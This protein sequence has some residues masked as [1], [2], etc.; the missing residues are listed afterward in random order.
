MFL[1]Q[2]GKSPAHDR[3][4]LAW[5][6]PAVAPCRAAPDAGASAGPSRSRASVLSTE[7]RRG[8]MRQNFCRIFD[9]CITY[10]LP[11]RLLMSAASSAGPPLRRD[12]QGLGARPQAGAGSLDRKGA[13]SCFAAS[14]NNELRQSHQYH[15]NSMLSLVR[16]ASFVVQKPSGGGR[17]PRRD[18]WASVN[19]QSQFRRTGRSW[20]PIVPNKPN[21]GGS[22]GGACGTNKANFRPDRKEPGAPVGSIVR[23]KAKKQ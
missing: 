5:L 1:A 11:K 10:G 8:R 23:N 7:V 16:S 9:F 13:P 18:L 15:R 20:R 6:G 2:S 12:R 17:R 22:I 3:R 21:P 4:G 14:G 19:K